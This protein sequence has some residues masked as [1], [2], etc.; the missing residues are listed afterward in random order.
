MLFIKKKKTK[1]KKK[2]KKHFCQEGLV[3]KRANFRHKI[4]LQ[5]I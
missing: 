3:L 1:N 5:N 2:K 4:P